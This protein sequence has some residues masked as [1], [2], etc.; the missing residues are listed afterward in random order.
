[1]RR[2]ALG[3]LITTARVLGKD[4]RDDQEKRFLTASENGQEKSEQW[5]LSQRRR[6]ESSGG[7]QSPTPFGTELDDDEDLRWNMFQRYSW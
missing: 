3:N 2:Q 6:T 7:T 5:I 4:L 1:M